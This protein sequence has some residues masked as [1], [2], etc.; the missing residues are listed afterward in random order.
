[1]N[2]T[3]NNT[4]PAKMPEF[5]PAMLMAAMQQMQT[6]LESE[7]MG[8]ANI[9]VLGDIDADQ[10]TRAK[11]LLEGCLHTLNCMDPGNCDLVLLNS[12]NGELNR[13]AGEVALDLEWSVNYVD[14]IED[15]EILVTVGVSEKVQVLRETHEGPCIELPL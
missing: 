10:T 3:V 15:M 2:E 8:R 4:E 13:V 14:T 1:M 12:N 11:A 5:D 7:N 6:Q 9:G